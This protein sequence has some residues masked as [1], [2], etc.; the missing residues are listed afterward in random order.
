MDEV[1][2]FVVNL[3][4]LKLKYYQIKLVAKI[5]IQVLLVHPTLNVI[6]VCHA[7]LNLGKKVFSQFAARSW[8]CI[9]L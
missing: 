8:Q 5:Q 2:R 9:P 4:P 6:A 3:K 1:G 7:A